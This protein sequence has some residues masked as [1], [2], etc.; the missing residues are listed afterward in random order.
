MASNSGASC[1][2]PWR[3]GPIRARGCVCSSP[4]CQRLH[5][6]VTEDL[7]RRSFIGGV[8]AMLAPFA[9]PSGAMAT[10]ANDKRP[11]LLTNLRFV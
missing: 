4:M 9:L 10:T 2:F 7:S 11:L 6:R 3:F 8:A 5:Q 1:G